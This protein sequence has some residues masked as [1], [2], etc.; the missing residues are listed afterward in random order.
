MVV[1]CTRGCHTRYDKHTRSQQPRSII[2]SSI[3]KWLLWVIVLTNTTI[4]IV[5]DITTGTCV[6]TVIIDAFI[7]ILV[8]K[9]NYDVVNKVCGSDQ[10]TRSRKPAT[11]PKLPL[12]PESV[13]TINRAAAGDHGLAAR[14]RFP[15]NQFVTL[16]Y[17]CC[18]YSNRYCYNYNYTNQSS[19]IWYCKRY[20]SVYQI[21]WE[22]IQ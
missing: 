22:L 11:I 8:N 17:Y 7:K 2:I 15:L 9:G 6:I 18:K 13:I 3:N 16:S 10:S 1:S 20:N 5:T 12:T 14:P 19:K 21:F 4:D